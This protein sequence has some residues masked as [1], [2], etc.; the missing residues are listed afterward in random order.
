MP[1]RYVRRQAPKRRVNYSRTKE[2]V[3]GHGPTLLERIA[4]GVGSAAKL[5]TAVAPIIEAINTESKYHDETAAFTS[6]NTA[7]NA[8]VRCL[9]DGIT[10]GVTDETRIGNSILAQDLQIRLAISQPV[11]HNAVPSNSILGTFHRVIIFVWKINDF[12]GPTVAKLLEDPTNIYSPMNKDYT[13]QFVVMKDKHMVLNAQM[14]PVQSTVTVFHRSMKYYKKLNW[15]MRWD[16]AGNDVANHVWML[17][18]STVTGATNAVG[19]TFYS[20]LNFTDN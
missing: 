9:T 2:L 19:T 1:R 18:M 3:V 14:P 17:T 10:Q 15:H 7:T 13:D 4:S 11:T 20:R 5:A 6:Y 12:G 8:D 16:D